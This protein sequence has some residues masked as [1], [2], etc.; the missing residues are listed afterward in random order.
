MVTN[1]AQVKL[2]WDAAWDSGEIGPFNSF[3]TVPDWAVQPDHLYR[4][5]VK[6]KDVTGRWSQWSLPIEFRPSPR[7]TIS[8]LK[9]N[10]VFNEI[11]YNAAGQGATAET[12]KVLELKNI[13]PFALNLS[14]LFIQGITFTFTNGT[15]LAPGATFT[16]W[17]EIPPCLQRAIRA[18]WSMVSTPAS[19]ITVAKPSPSAIQ[20]RAKSLPSPTATALPGPLRPTASVTPWCS[21]IQ[22]RRPIVRVRRSTALRVP[23]AN[24]NVGGVVINEILA[25]TLR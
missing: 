5:R 9:T 19:S 17:P 1:P 3:M 8:Q 15:T 11:M 24:L 18:S 13:G 23:T 22:P 6:H 4:V 10:L 2:E 21:P 16:K 20:P 14:G 12:N 7:D 25:F